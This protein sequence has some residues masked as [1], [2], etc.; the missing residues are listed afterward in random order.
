[1][2]GANEVWSQL[3]K[4]MQY[5]DAIVESLHVVTDFHGGVIGLASDTRR[6]SHGLIFFNW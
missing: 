3:G 4:M 2:S 5:T 1:M 6:Q